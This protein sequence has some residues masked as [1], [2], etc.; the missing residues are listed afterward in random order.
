MKQLY[1]KLLY[2][3]VFLLGSTSG[4]LAQTTETFED[5]SLNSTT[6]TDNSQTF[7]ITSSTGET[8]DVFEVAGA[9][10][11]GTTADDKF[12]EN[13]ASPIPPGDGSSFTI[14]A[15][16]GTDF[17]VLDL[18]LFCATASLS[19]HTGNL[20]IT[21]RK[22]GSQVFSF[23]KTS[24]FNNPTNLGVNNGFTFIDFATEGA[25]DFTDD[26]IDEL[27]F[28]STNNLD[29]MALD[30]FRWNAIAGDTNPPNV[31]SITVNGSPN[32]TDEQ[33]DFI[34]TFN[35]IA[36]NVTT[37]DFSIDATGSATGTINTISGSGTSYTINV[38]NLSGEGTISIDLNASTDIQDALGNNGPPA[39]TSGDHHTVSACF[40]E[41]FEGTAVNATTFGSNGLPFTATNGLRIVEL[42]DAGASDSDRYLDNNNGGAGTYAIQSTGGEL[43][44][45]S[46]LDLYLSSITGGTT[47]TNDGTLTIN[48]KVAGSTVYT[49]T[50][51]SGFP[52]TLNNGDNGF[53]N[54]NFATDGSSDYTTTN[55]D[56]V[57][58]V[59]GAAFTYLAIDHFEFCEE[60]TADTFPPEIQSIT[61]A[62]SPTST[63]TS[64]DFTVTF[65]ENV[66]NVTTDDFSLDTSGTT[67][68][69]SGITGNNNIYTVTVDNITGQGTISIDLNASTDIEDALGNSGPPAFTTGEDHTVSPC[70]VETFESF[71][72]GDTS[73]SSNGFM[74]NLT[75]GLDVFNINGA[76]ANGSDIFLDNEGNGTGTY[77]IET[78]DN[79][80]FTVNTLSLYVSSI[81]AGSNP[82]DD[83]TVTIRGKV[84]GTTVYTIDLNNTNTTFPTAVAQGNNG[85]LDLDFSSINGLD[86]SN[87][88]IDEIEFEIFADFTYIAVDN[89]EFC[90]DE[91]PPVVQSIALQGTPAENATTVT[92]TVTFDE[93]A[94]NITTDDFELTTT[95]TAS[96]S[97]ASVS[98]SSGTSVNVTINTIT[99]DG[100]LRLDLL[101]NTD[102]T[103]STGNGN[104]T[105]GHVTA[106]T[107]GEV[108]NLDLE[109]PTA[110]IVIDDTSIISGETPTVTITFS[111][112]VSGFDNS[113][114]S[115]DNGTL[116]NVSSSDGN[117]TFTA[118][119]TPT[120][121][122]DDANNIIALTNSGVTDA[123]GNTGT[124]TTDSNNYAIDTTIPTATIVIDDTTIISGETPTVTI[125]FSEAVSGFDN[126]DLS[127]DNGTLS[128]VASSD[129]NVTFTATFTPTTNVDDSSNLITLT[130]SGVTD[131]SGNPGTGTTDSNNY[132]IDTTIPTA[133]IVIDDTS[134]ISG[135]TP[136]VT[137]TFSEAVSGFDN[138]DLSIDNGTLSNVASS[139]G[140]IT[141]TATFTPTT[142]VDDASNLITLTNSG[143]TDAAGNP[144][145]G[146]T[147]S[148]NYAI[149]NIIPTATIVIDDTT[150]I[151]G[152]TP[153]VTITFSEAV[154]GFDNSDLSIDNGTLSNVAS[155]DG[156]IT[157]TATFT[158]NA[159]VNDS[160]NLITLTNSGV[161]DVAGNPGTGTTDSNNYAIDNIIPTAT[162]VIDD[163]TIISGE[164]PTVTITF[165]EAVSGFDNSDLS[166]DNGTLSNVAS[167]DGN[168]TFTATFTPSTNV[169]DAS[170]LITLTNSGVTDVAGNPGMGTTDS[171]NYALETIVPT[172]TITSSESSPTGENP[173]PVTI[174]FSENISGFIM[175]DITVTNG[176][177]TNFNETTAGLIYDIEITPDTNGLITINIAANVAND[178][179][180]NPN[181]TATEFTITYDSTLSTNDFTINNDSFY[182][183]PN[184][185]Q[186]IISFSHGSDIEIHTVKLFNIQGRSVF[187]KNMNTNTSKT[188]DI[189]NLSNG[190]YFARFFSNKG[191]LT[192][193]IIKN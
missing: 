168:I 136:T 142:N 186:G 27:V 28:T 78:S 116:S 98:A 17:L 13:T 68:N 30:A 41:S 140:N 34:V 159:N 89:F 7:T 49:I 38:N 126:S 20:T 55:V 52:T 60:G 14:A 8:Y 75:N 147:D 36:S 5:E 101:A 190:V 58:L 1:L 19:S 153:T 125:T 174:T 128:N 175:G 110:T 119:F 117:I 111:E 18:Y 139:D 66:S 104:G 67:G 72:P 9:G 22:D 167:S 112:A 158:P 54:I 155:S 63:A 188:I 37:D 76:G 173:I 82:T 65:N 10:W 144:G 135:E 100:S 16:G 114:L 146:T 137:I 64:V 31:Q 33:V 80:T 35:E 71:T 171:N 87:T 181:D 84:N 191:I 86:H 176:S 123:A 91:T 32:T 3:L 108:H 47:P 134:I 15:N 107:T 103:D 88:S 77:A 2:G 157:F 62:G 24:G 51:N 99:G 94:N 25:S 178:T 109:V 79:S 44:T 138:S 166:I 57:E 26:P 56:E 40:L 70:A 43:F 42:T 189:T 113:D 193:R 165:S 163:T 184:P 151:S 115:I 180:G 21:G 46:T 53:F 45:M 132:A 156:N 131:V 81:A 170:N 154:S 143:V 74:F 121:N 162:I 179:S 69:I 124:G 48:G 141:F 183:Y 152:E 97:I 118:T 106:F 29:Y 6:F 50:K 83:G 133:T 150:I 160:S 185:S 102:I 149:D 92:Y 148:N 164:T 4:I 61:V 122:V 23:T 172:V 39:F 127:I 96:A 85:F 161:T 93:I 192:Q 169:D 187:S 182:I 90:V 177:V 129:G 73:F 130:N 105:N 59:I 11:N 95:G 145:T 120:T 12:I